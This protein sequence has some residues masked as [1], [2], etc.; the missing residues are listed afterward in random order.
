M[1][2]GV[3]G[4]STAGWR[5]AVGSVT[6]RRVTAVVAG[7]GMSGDVRRVGA[8]ASA[9]ATSARGV[10]RGSF[11]A[12]RNVGVAD[13]SGSTAGSALRR[14]VLAVGC[15]VGA[16]ASTFGAGRAVGLS[17]GR[18]AT[19]RESGAGSVRGATSGRGSLG[20]GTST[21]WFGGTRAVAAWRLSRDAS[22]AARGT[23]SA[24]CWR[25]VVGDSRRGSVSGVGVGGR[26]GVGGSGCDCCR[27]TSTAGVS[28]V[29]VSTG[30]S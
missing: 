20:R 2:A 24:G 10:A 16:G 9:A 6:S 26:T 5:A 23:V 11:T 17:V 7:C 15:D 1:G 27:S 3:A 13:R 19:L 28:G 14:A 25:A 12:R 22:S 8:G 21:V 18:R 29:S 30:F 4:A